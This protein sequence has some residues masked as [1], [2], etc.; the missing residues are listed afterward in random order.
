[1]PT[2]IKHG[3]DP[4]TTFMFTCTKCGCVYVSRFRSEAKVMT[5]ECPEAFCGTMNNGYPALDDIEAVHIPM[6]R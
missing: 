4:R 6:K 5:L 3:K 1:M 2:V